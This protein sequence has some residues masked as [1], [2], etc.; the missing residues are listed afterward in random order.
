M[1]K[2]VFARLALPLAIA[3]TGASPAPAQAQQRDWFSTDWVAECALDVSDGDVATVVYGPEPGIFCAY[4][5]YRLPSDRDTLT[6]VIIRQADVDEALRVL[7]YASEVMEDWGLVQPR[8]PHER[9]PAGAPL[10]ALAASSGWVLSI[11]PEILLSDGS[12]DALGMFDPRSADGNPEL[13]VAFDPLEGESGFDLE[14]RQTLV[15]ELFH[16]IQ[17]NYRGNPSANA[18]LHEADWV[19]E[20]MADGIADTILALYDAS[21]GV[22]SAATALQAPLTGRAR[23]SED[24]YSMRGGVLQDSGLAAYDTSSFWTHLFTTQLR[25]MREVDAMYRFDDPSGD[26]AEEFVNDWLAKTPARSLPLAVRAFMQDVVAD[27]S[28]YGGGL[29]DELLAC[30]DVNVTL[31]PSQPAPSRVVPFEGTRDPVLAEGMRV[32]CRVMVVDATQGAVRVS[33]EPELEGVPYSPD[34]QVFTGEAIFNDGDTVTLPAG[35]VHRMRLGI[36]YSPMDV[37]VPGEALNTADFGLRFEMVPE[38]ACEDMT[39][40]LSHDVLDDV[41]RLSDLTATVTP[42]PVWG[43]ATLSVAAMGEAHDGRAC[44]RLI[45]SDYGAG[46]SLTVQILRHPTAPGWDGAHAAFT[47]AMEAGLFDPTPLRTGGIL[48]YQQGFPVFGTAIVATPQEIP[49]QAG[50]FMADRP[51]ANT[52][53]TGQGDGIMVIGHHL[54]TSLTLEF[55]DVGS[56][57]A[58]GRFSLTTQGLGH[59]GGV[60]GG[61]QRIAASGSFTVP[62]Q[63]MGPMEDLAA[64]RVICRNA[65]IE[66]R[67]HDA[68]TCAR[69]H[70]DPAVVQEVIDFAALSAT[71]M[72]ESYIDLSDLGL[73]AAD[74]NDLDLFQGR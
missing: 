31:D 63:V 57:S 42:L 70:P 11:R 46:P 34:L 4:E 3:A 74:L 61:L 71:G 47:V 9:A 43:D 16:A 27:G 1:F 33:L 19:S 12:T 40:R 5:L 36:I 73:D 65:V 55:E 58:T 21:G 29:A 26:L 14:R 48:D 52:Y 64:W 45:L 60:Y 32:L 18:P 68:F 7:R 50:G 49:Y 53:S 69:G 39:A 6:R 67:I 15:H 28:F 35:Q 8:L 62:V 13:V 51:Y 37:V 56:L 38:L 25:D 66:G 23:V 2:A 20:G 44:M 41:T 54:N 72:L 30:T 17:A 22:V 10:A 59:R 24:R